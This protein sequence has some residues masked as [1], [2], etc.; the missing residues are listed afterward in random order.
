MQSLPDLIKTG[1]EENWFK[2]RIL[3]IQTSPGN[4]PLLTGLFHKYVCGKSL[5]ELIADALDKAILKRG[6][7]IG[8]SL[9]DLET[10]TWEFEHVKVLLTKLDSEES[11]MS[12]ELDWG[13]SL[14]RGAGRT[15]V[16][17]NTATEI[18]NHLKLA[19]PEGDWLITKPRSLQ[20]VID[21]EFENEFK[22]ADTFRAFSDLIKP[23]KQ[24]QVYYTPPPPRKRTESYLGCC[25]YARG[26]IKKPYKK[27]ESDTDTDIE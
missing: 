14:P 20:L 7:V 18:I 24:T 10:K 21:H 11:L 9:P 3:F 1:V 6:V 17:T 8:F 23:W 5:N 27:S 22:W 12:E 15:V 2:G 13:V 4:W 25:S 26:G 19:D 16:S